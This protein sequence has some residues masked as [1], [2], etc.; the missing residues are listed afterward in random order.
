[1]LRTIKWCELT[2]AFDRVLP[3]ERQH[4]PA[5]TAPVRRH[6]GVGREAVR[7]SVV[8]LL[9]VSFLRLVSLI[10]MAREST[11]PICIRLGDTLG[12]HLGIALLVTCISAIF[13]LISLSGEKEL[14]AESTHD[15]LVELA[16]DELMAVHLENIALSLPYGTLTTERFVRSAPTGDRVLD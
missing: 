10:S 14:L 7:D 12:D 2:R 1:M 15:G 11:H 5:M 8:D 4:V 3:T 6:V 9:L 16:L 13:A